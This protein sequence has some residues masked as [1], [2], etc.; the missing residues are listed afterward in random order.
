MDQHPQT[1]ETSHRSSLIKDSEKPSLRQWLAQLERHGQLRRIKAEVDWDEEIAAIA[2]VNLALSGPGLLFETIKG[3]REGRCGRFLTT[4]LANRTQVCLLVGLPPDA[5]DRRIVR[6]LKDTYR[7]RIPPATVTGGPVKENILHGD[8]INLLE[9]PVPKWHR[10]D[11]GRFIDTFCGV[12]TRDP[13]SAQLNV[14]LYRGQ[15]LGPRRIGKLIVPTQHWG[16]HFAQHRASMKPMEVAIV[17]GWHDVLPFCAG[18]FF[19]KTVCEYDMMGAIL[20]QSVELVKCETSELLVPASAEIVVEGTISPDPATFADEGPFAEYPGYAGGTASPK[21][22]VE[23]SCL[24]HRHDP[25]LRGT[26]EGARPGF[27]T[28]DSPICAYSWSAIAWNMLEDAGVGGVTDVWMPPVSTGTNIVVQIQKRYR[29]HAQQV[30]AALWGTGAAQWVF[31]NVMVVEEDIDIRDPVALDWAFA[32][33]VNAAEGQV[34][35]FGPTFGSVLDPS[36]P[37][38]QADGRKYGTGNWTR[39]LIDATRN[40][41]FEP[42]PAWGGR[43]FPPINTLDPALEEQICRRWQEYGIGID[44]LSDDQRELL[45]FRELSRRFP[46]I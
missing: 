10:L 13:D 20:G 39:L 7:R 23:V 9:F 36:T 5:P 31:K 6:H 19:P 14:G 21:P 34:S 24:T 35:T 27:P 37:R 42:N 1:P 28:E 44:Y 29:G 45:T 41:E 46:E 16:T 32:F 11:G 40:W 22:V 4:A 15:V 33:R 25:I 3:Y 30:A 8:A 26:L 12:I 18:S 17:Y 43:R 38:H 2:R